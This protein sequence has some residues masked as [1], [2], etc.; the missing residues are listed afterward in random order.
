VLAFQND[1]KAQGNEGRVLTMVFSEF[2]RRVKQ[3]ASNGTDHGTAAPMFLIGPSMKAGVC[4]SHPSLTDLD[5][6]DLKYGIDFRSV[7]TSV[8][9]DWMKAP[10]DKILRGKF[11]KPE[12]IVAKA[13]A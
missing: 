7:Y 6:G 5:Q 2:G 8:L 4:G 1:M 3:N 10:A 13:K 9:E 11:A 12:L